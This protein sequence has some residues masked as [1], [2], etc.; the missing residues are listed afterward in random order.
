M[1]TGGNTWGLF[2]IDFLHVDLLHTSL[3]VYRYLRYVHVL[4]LHSLFCILTGQV[5]KWFVEQNNIT[6]GFYRMLCY[7]TFVLQ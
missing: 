6:K 3:T 5:V 2:R 4:G 1:W 7:F